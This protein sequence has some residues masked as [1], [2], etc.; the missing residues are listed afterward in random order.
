M[1]GSRFLELRRY[2]Y[3]V[4][5]TATHDSDNKLF[6]IRPVVYIVRKKCV[7]VMSE[8]YHS[9]KQQIIPPKTKYTKIWQY[10]PKKTQKKRV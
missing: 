7:K 8:E 1:S 4:D 5:N 3:F 10:N 2:L 9:V 6:K